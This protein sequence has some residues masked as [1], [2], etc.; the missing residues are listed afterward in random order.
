[1]RM[2]SVRA[3]HD[4]RPVAPTSASQSA[5]VRHRG[6]Q[7]ETPF[8]VVHRADIPVTR[9]GQHAESLVVHCAK[10][11]SEH[12]VPV[13]LPVHLPALQ[14]CPMAHDPH[15]LPQLSTPHT[16]PAHEHIDVLP[17]VQVPELQDCPMG[18][19]P[20]EDP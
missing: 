7:N 8:W 15:E 19:E 4:S 2:P 5:V 14:V 13:L 10:S 16:R 6:A 11:E 9:L 3:T 12:M 17:P 18:H 20:H 1:M